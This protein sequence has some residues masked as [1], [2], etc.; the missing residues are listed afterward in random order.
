MLQKV[1][2]LPHSAPVSPPLNAHLFLQNPAEWCDELEGPP[3]EEN[4]DFIKEFPHP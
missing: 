3:W 2:R 4:I 1:E